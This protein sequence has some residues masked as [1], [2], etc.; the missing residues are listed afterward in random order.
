MPRT[1]RDV[2][3]L[4]RDWNDTILWYARAVKA[5]SARPFSDLTSWRYL[6]ALPGVA[7]QLWRGDGYMKPGE[8][9]PC[10]CNDGRVRVMLKIP[11]DLGA[12]SHTAVAHAC[13]LT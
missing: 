11:F 6:A 2:G 8:S 7:G 3:K 10:F 5:M 4:G 9:L 12:P 1:R 13:P